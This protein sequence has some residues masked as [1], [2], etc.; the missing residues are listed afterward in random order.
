M[1]PRA[2]AAEARADLS[3][4]CP[5]IEFSERTLTIAAPEPMRSLIA[6]EPVLRRHGLAPSAIDFGHRDLEAVFL[7]LTHRQLRD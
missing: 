1:L 2:P 3:A 7:E 4:A 6:L 5:G